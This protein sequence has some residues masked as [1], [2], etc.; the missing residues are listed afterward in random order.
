MLFKMF[1]IKVRQ[2]LVMGGSFLVGS[3]NWAFVSFDPP[4]YDSLIDPD[5]SA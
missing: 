5:N 1:G 4:G 3:E 2:I